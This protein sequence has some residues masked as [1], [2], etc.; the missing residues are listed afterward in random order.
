MN[1]IKNLLIICV[2]AAVGYGV[3]QSLQRNNVDPEWPVK[4]KADASGS[5]SAK[6]SGG[7][8]A[9]GGSD[10]RPAPSSP[11]LGTGRR[12]AAAC[13]ASGGNTSE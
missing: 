9:L 7:S 2:L 11:A 6:A 8:L 13:D 4:P 5:K 10:S 12:G 1:A 3:Y